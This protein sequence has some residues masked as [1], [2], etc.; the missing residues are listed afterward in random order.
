LTKHFYTGVDDVLEKRIQTEGENNFSSLCTRWRVCRRCV[1]Y[2][3]LYARRTR[4]FFLSHVVYL[5]YA[6]L[7]PFC[8]PTIK[9][10]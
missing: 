4:D 9:S 2:A 6:F 1:R 3:W 10:G 7:P 5:P 8:L